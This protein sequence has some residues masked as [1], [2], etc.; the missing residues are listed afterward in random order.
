MGENIV[1]RLIQISFGDLI[2]PVFRLFFY[3]K[4]LIFVGK[5]YPESALLASLSDKWLI[6]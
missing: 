4:N 1:S 2:E 6:T 5:F 3:V